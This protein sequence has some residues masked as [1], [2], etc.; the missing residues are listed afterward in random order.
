MEGTGRQSL[1]EPPRGAAKQ[2]PW[3][4]GSPEGQCPHAPGAGALGEMG[5]LGGLRR[6]EAEGTF[7]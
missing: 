4:S 1:R 5:P 3:G 7:Y 6:E 2:R